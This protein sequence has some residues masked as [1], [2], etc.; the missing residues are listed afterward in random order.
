[1]VVSQVVGVGI[2]LTPATML[3]TIGGVRS[4]LILWGT[5]GALSI[6]GAFCY[7]EL[8][9]RFPK[10]GGGYVFLREAFGPRAAF[11][12]GWISLLVTD[13]GITAAL[14]I[15]FA[16]YLLAAIGASP[17]LV[18]A[19][20]VVAVLAFALLTLA[21][22]GVSATLLHWTA[23]AKLTTVG[24]LVAAA[25]IRGGGTGFSGLTASGAAGGLGVEAIAASVIAAF[26]AFG[27]WWEL[28]RMTEEVESP[29][30]VMPRALVGGLT[31]VTAIYVSVTLAY[32]LAAGRVEGSDEA[33]MAA[34]GAALFGETAG[35]LL[36][37]MVV[38]AVAGSLTATL[39]ASPRMYLAMA[40]DGVFP[41]RLARVDAARGALPAA[42]LI[43]ASLACILILVGTFEQ[44]LG[45]FV[46][47]TIFFLGL[48]AAAILKLPRPAPDSQVFVAPAHPLPILAFLALILTLLVLFTVG[49]PLQTLLG[50]LV[51]ATGFLVSRNFSSRTT[52]P[53]P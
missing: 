34:V 5:M 2:F 43:Q 25:A 26:F 18:P 17:T 35:R 52:H 45:Y 16:Q 48:S 6:A 37:V 44:I 51:A 32:L 4:A 38:V 49:Q 53:A 1:M 9:T 11:V 19:V 12:S 29:R 41:P 50:A 15:G 23:I 13:P 20:A 27:G 14:S 33:F 28:G 40:R 10:A 7:A 39:L 47:V 3:R 42:T 8:T 31:L 22:I 36:A 24:I 30:R 21:G 46:P